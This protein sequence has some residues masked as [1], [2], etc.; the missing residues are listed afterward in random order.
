MAHRWEAKRRGNKK[1]DGR[2]L[3]IVA[4]SFSGAE[5]ETQ[6]SFIDSAVRVREFDLTLIARRLRAAKYTAVHPEKR[7]FGRWALLYE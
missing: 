1:R 5:P 3:R 2:A 6:D 7:D 4:S